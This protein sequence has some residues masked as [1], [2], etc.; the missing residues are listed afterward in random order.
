MTTVSR[1]SLVGTRSFSEVSTRQLSITFT[2]PN[3]Y[4]MLFLLSSGF[5][6]ILDFLSDVDMVVVPCFHSNH[7]ETYSGFTTS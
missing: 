2:R 7:S 5:Q 6:R 1:R 4:R 3:P